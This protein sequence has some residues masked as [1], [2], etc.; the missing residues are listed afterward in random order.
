MEMNEP[1]RNGYSE[2][3]AGWASVSAPTLIVDMPLDGLGVLSGS[4]LLTTQSL[5][6]GRD[7]EPVE[8][9]VERRNRRPPVQNLFRT[10]NSGFIS[11]TAKNPCVR[12]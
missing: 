4:A 6:T 2:N 10:A 11:S 9:L 3:A 5:P 8:G 12:W 7:P 1:A